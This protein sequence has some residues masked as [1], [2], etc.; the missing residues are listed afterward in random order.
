MVRATGADINALQAIGC[1]ATVTLLTL[2]PVAINGIGI[3]EAGLVGLLTIL[4][5]TE[6]DAAQAAVCLRLVLVIA[7]LPGVCWLRVGRPD[8]KKTFS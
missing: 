2:V 8:G 5:V 7:A 1:I 3:Y 4:G 6:T